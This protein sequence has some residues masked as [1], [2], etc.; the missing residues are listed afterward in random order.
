MVVRNNW[1]RCKDSDLPGKIISGISN[2][3]LTFPDTFSVK[4]FGC[5][6]EIFYLHP[7]NRRP[8]ET[9]KELMEQN[10]ESK[11]ISPGKAHLSYLR[12]FHF[13]A[14]YDGK[15]KPALT[16]MIEQ[17]NQLRLSREK[18]ALRRRTYGNT[19]VLPLKR[20][21]VKHHFTDKHI[22]GVDEKVHKMF[23]TPNK[24]DHRRKMAD[25]IKEYEPEKYKVMQE[26]YS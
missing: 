1:G 7:N 20:G 6:I 24:E 5:K 26:Y 13:P 3:E 21:E 15:Y 17:R 2:G 8:N 10:D 4:C 14:W 11:I 12:C 22:I 19:I 9:D 16:E 18:T 23:S 25:Y